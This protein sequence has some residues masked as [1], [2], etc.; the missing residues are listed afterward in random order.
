MLAVP[1]DDIAAAR[2]R[3][4]A[5]CPDWASAVVDAIASHAKPGP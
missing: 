2:A 3:Y 5:A 4:V 1:K